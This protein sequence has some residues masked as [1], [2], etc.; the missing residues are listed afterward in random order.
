M[1]DG[2]ILPGFGRCG[3][4]LPQ[5]SLVESGVSPLEIHRCGAPSP[6]NVVS[7]AKVSTTHTRH[8]QPRRVHR[9]WRRVGLATLAL[10]LFVGTAAATVYRSLPDIDALDITDLVNDPTGDPDPTAAEPTTEA[11]PNAGRALTILIIGSDAREAGV[12]DDGVTSVLADTHILMHIA[13][14]RS[15]VEM[16]S[17]PRDILVD[18]PECTTSSGEIIPAGSGQY[19]DAFALGWDRGGD[20][21]SAVACD[22]NLLQSATGITPDG[23]VLVNMGGFVE[24]INAIGGVDICIPEAI[25]APKADG[26]VL[27]AGQQRLNGTQALGYARARTGVGVGDGSDTGRIERQ[28]HLIAAVTDELLSRNLLTDAGQLFNVASAALDSLTTS[29]ELASIPGLIGLARSLQAVGSENVTFTTSPFAPYK[30]NPNRL[31]W[32]DEADL[33]WDAILSDTPISVALGEEPAAPVT[34]PATVDPGTVPGTPA[35]DGGATDP[36]APA[37]TPPSDNS[38]QALNAVCG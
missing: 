32:T 17:I 21:A 23:F 24:V 16:V 1:R 33:V 7:V 31:V 30:P 34:D 36:A 25:D 11:D 28:Q 2:P 4:R 35:A 3:K 26:L 5:R 37:T 14:D 27:A 18:L 15:R 38:A 8:A 19:N 22:I 13:A 6:D 10:L 12:I 29:P 9:A 20:L